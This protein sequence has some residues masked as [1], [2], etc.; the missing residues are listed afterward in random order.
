M[1]VGIDE[2]ARLIGRS[3]RVVRYL[4]KTGKLKTRREGRKFLIATADLPL[5]EKARLELDKKYAAARKAVD[6]AIRRDGSPLLADEPSL[7]PLPALPEDPARGVGANLAQ[8]DQR[9]YALSELDVTQHLLV[10]FR[11]LHDMSS[12]IAEGE[13]GRT[14][15]HLHRGLR[16]LSAGFYLFDASSRSVALNTARVEFAYALAELLMIRASLA[17]TQGSDDLN[18]CLDTWI[19]TLETH[20]MPAMAGLLRR[21]ER[22]R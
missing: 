14:L 15:S 1:D 16:E 6:A 13:R 10:M 19:Y 22:R 12:M 17:T 8:R 20:I 3:S 4:I 9:R 7:A 5:T 21:T 18:R 2:A 11:S